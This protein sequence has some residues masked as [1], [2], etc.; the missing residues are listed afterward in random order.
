MWAGFG[1]AEKLRTAHA[2]EPPMHLAAAIG[3]ALKIRE[4]AFDGDRFG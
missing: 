4:F 3:D 2:T 1:F